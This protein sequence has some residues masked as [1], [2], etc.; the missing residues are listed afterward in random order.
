MNVGIAQIK[1]SKGNITA[2]IEKH[3]K[4][5]ELASSF[6]ATSVFFPE[7]SL[8]GYEPELAK[9]L[10]IYKNDERLDVFQ[11]ICNLRN[12]TI[13]V[14]IPIKTQSGIQISMIVFRPNQD[15]IIYSK[16]QLHEDEFPY[17]EKGN[18]QV[19][20]EVERQKIIPAICYE[21]L[22]I[23]HAENASKLGGEIY[24]ASV[25]KSKGGVEKAF[26]YYPEVAKKYAMPVLMANC[27][28][29]CDNFVTVGFSSVWNKEGKLIAQ[30]NNENEGIII[31]N[32]KTEKIIKEAI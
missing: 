23:K 27:I 9:D 31:F 12:I 2:N 14:G 28:G 7:L 13:G 21:S 32:T 24:L 22:Q 29:E 10:A 19:I 3:I 11:D 4:F 15:Q 18:E 25:A 26:I 30:L 17:F 6:K 1:S 20:I 8:T 16:Q 5:V